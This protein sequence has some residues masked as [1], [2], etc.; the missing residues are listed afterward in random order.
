MENS[1]ES[2]TQQLQT[3][4]QKGHEK[5]LLSLLS[6]KEVFERHCE[7]YHQYFCEVP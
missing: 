2:Q 3:F 5:S 1:R 7:F 4:E 6:F